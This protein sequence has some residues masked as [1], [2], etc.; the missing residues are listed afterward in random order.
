MI[1]SDFVVDKIAELL[2]RTNDPRQETS[3]TDETFEMVEPLMNVFR[4][5]VDLTMEAQKE[6]GWEKHFGVFGR[7]VT[8]FRTVDTTEK[9]LDGVPDK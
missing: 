1:F 5:T 6:I 9:I 4:E 8:M 2:S 7:G 3:S